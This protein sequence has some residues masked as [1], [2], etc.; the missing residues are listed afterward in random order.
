MSL[1]LGRLDHIPPCHGRD[2]WPPSR[3]GWYLP[4]QPYGFE[5]EDTWHPPLAVRRRFHFVHSWI[6]TTFPIAS[7]ESR[8]I[9]SHLLLSAGGLVHHLLRVLNIRHS[10]YIS[11]DA[12][13]TSL[14]ALTGSKDL[15]FVFQSPRSRPGRVRHHRQR[16]RPSRLL[17]GFHSRV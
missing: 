4:F 1:E 10:R 8:S 14:S 9:S 11:L 3:T 15:V 7:L 2:T 5:N 16:T 13:V 17:L 6:C 12:L